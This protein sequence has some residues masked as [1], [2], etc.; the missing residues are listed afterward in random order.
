MK[1]LFILLQHIAPQLTLTRAAGALAECKLPWIKNTFIK[2]YIKI[3]KVNMSEAE[4]PNPTSYACFN[5]FFCRALK[6]NARQFDS[7]NDS[8]ISPVDG[9][10]SQLGNIE[11]GTLFQAKGRQFTTNELLAGDSAMAQLFD[12]GQFATIYLSP[13]DYHRMH[14]P[15]AGKL[16]SMQH[17]AGKLFSVNPT[18]VN[19]VD[20][21]FARNERV[22]CLF[23]TEHGPMALV[24][25]GAMI[26]ASVE[27]VWHG[28]VKRDKNGIS[29]FFY[30]HQ[31]IEF[32][33][34]AEFARFK[35]G[36][37]IILL[38]PENKLSWNDNYQAGSLVKLGESIA[39]LAH[40]DR[41]SIAR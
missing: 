6:D 8:I 2:I 32:K 38:F 22:V 41:E 40:T 33:K 5:D 12:Y 34:A 14:M 24:L 39:K 13:K 25:V 20:R 16:V 7:D 26:V 27:T 29:Q 10:F 1:S 17:V 23:E 3:F 15:I 28:L 4:D 19:G 30:H 9:R 18:T 35:L 31:N 11:N 37:T 36:S 21:L